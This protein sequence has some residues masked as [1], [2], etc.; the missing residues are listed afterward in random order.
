VTSR[1]RVRAALAHAPPDATPCDYYATG[2]IHRA[3]RAHFGLP[4]APDEH[5]ILG[6]SPA[7]AVDNAIADRLGTDIRYVAPPYVGQPPRAFDDGSW[8]NLWG[9]RLKP[10]P[11]AFGEYAE[12]AGIA[13]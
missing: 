1:E 6:S 3:L 4:D 11:N 2:E 12:S 5:S 8:T 7:K 13:A 9:V 10:M